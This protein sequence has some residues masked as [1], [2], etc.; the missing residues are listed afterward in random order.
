MNYDI[1]NII[2]TFAKKGVDNTQYN[3][4]A[5][6]NLNEN[7]HT[8]MLLSFLAYRDIN[9]RYPVLQSFLSSFAKGR[10]KMIHYKRPSNVELQFS[11]CLDTDL[12]DGLITFEAGGKKHAVIIEN[13]IFDAPDQPGQVR[14]YINLVKKH[15]DVALD[16]IWVFYITGDGNKVVDRDSYDT[17]NEQQETNI[18]NR[19]VTLSYS[20][21]IAQW[22]VE[23]VVNAGIYPEQ[24]T[25]VARVYTNYLLKHLF[26]LDAK[27]TEQNRLLA[28]LKLSKDMKKWKREEI[29]GLYNMQKEISSLRRNNTENNNIDIDRESLDLFYNTL[30]SLLNRLEELAFGEFERMTA[31]F[32]NT[33]WAK[34]MKK[35]GTEW[36]VAHRAVAGQNGYVQVRCVD[37]WGSA[38]LEWSNIS[39]AD[40][41]C[42]TKYHLQLHVEGNKQL[43]SEWKQDLE[44]M[45]PLLPQNAKLCSTSRVMK[46]EVNTTTPISQMNE[47]TLKTF[48]KGIYT[49]KM[50][51]AC[52]LLVERIKDY[53]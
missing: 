2:A 52:R 10:D 26:C 37:S 19:F 24:L 27:L 11:T 25:A 46:I 51:R 15:K 44:S 36:R 35:A 29:E 6:L 43:A 18:G 39:T 48:V 16:N 33:H 7:G 28:I 47:E 40:M 17:V 22:I 50:A 53:K 31:D 41:M 4:F 1:K 3:P 21:D 49:N 38:H 14:R 20:N 9:G 34:E 8:K 5:M 13:K 23:H 32:L 12:I 30:S 45:L 42:G